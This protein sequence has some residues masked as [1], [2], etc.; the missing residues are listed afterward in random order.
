MLPYYITLICLLFP[1]I[2]I[3][4]KRL[5]VLYLLFYPVSSS[6]LVMTAHHRVLTSMSP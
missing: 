6:H 3:K 4:S 5:N 2:E 1:Y